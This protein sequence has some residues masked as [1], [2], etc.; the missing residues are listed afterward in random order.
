MTA[1]E[2][3]N[4][5]LKKRYHVYRRLG[6][7]SKT[8]RVLSQRALDVSDLEISKRTGVLKRN[9]QTK[10]FVTVKMKDWKAEQAIDQYVK[11]VSTLKN[12]TVLSKFGMIVRD[13]RYK[14]ETGRVIAI[15]KS[16]HNLTTDQAYYFYYMIQTQGL[17]YERAKKELLTDKDFEIYISKNK[18]RAMNPSEFEKT[19]AKMKKR[20]IRY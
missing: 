1:R 16:R 6:Y 19:I 12:D 18:K 9:K 2:K 17:D 20:K 4:E 10:E 13:K 5:T 11:K 7:D 14:G 15:L 8:S 3:R